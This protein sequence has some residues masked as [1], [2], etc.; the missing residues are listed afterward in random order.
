MLEGTGLK[1]NYL[2]PRSI[3]ILAATIAPPRETAT[4]TPSGDE[5]QEVI[6]TANR[7]E[8]NL[9]NV[10]IAIQVLTGETL[11]K[12]NATTFDALQL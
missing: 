5:L 2:T 3:R 7:R 9:Q 1:F 4:T 11:A 12:L 8:E 10:P 6:V